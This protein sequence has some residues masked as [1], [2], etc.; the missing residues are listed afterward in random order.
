MHVGVCVPL[1]LE[2]GGLVESL[3]EV[4]VLLIV[5]DKR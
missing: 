3:L 4:G 5:H 2:L 1:A